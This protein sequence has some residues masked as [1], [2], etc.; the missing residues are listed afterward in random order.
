MEKDSSGKLHLHHAAL[1]FVD[2]RELATIQNDWS[3]ANLSNIFF[4]QQNNEINDEGDN[5]DSNDDNNDDDPVLP[6]FDVSSLQQSKNNVIE[7]E[8]VKVLDL[9]MAS[10]LTTVMKTFDSDAR[11]PLH[12]YIE[13]LIKSVVQN[14][15]SSRDSA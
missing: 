12:C 5:D 15:A 1:H 11:L 9:S 14:E 13:T 4:Q 10:L 7:G 6:S 8:A 3:E 2:P